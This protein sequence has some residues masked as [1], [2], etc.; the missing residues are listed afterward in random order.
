MCTDEGFSSL[1]F[2]LRNLD[3]GDLGPWGCGFRSG[4]MKGL[5][6][7]ACFWVRASAGLGLSM[8]MMLD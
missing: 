6:L 8:R 3:E 1:C 2:T 4:V 5:R 7:V